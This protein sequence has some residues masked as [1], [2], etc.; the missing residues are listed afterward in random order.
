MSWFSR[1][2]NWWF[3]QPGFGENA[4]VLAWSFDRFAGKGEGNQPGRLLP[5]P[6]T[7]DV[8]SLT[9][10]DDQLATLFQVHSGEWRDELDELR[11]HYA[12]FGDRLPSAIR[13]QLDQL[14]A[15]LDAR[16]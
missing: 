15:R 13:A 11:A 7:F 6:G 4:R 8:Q 9:L 12:T 14:A 2:A 5:A 1:D 16:R 3:L 10:A